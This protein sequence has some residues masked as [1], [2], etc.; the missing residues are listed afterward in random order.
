MES[1]VNFKNFWK[2]KRVL[3]TGHTGFK[4]GWLSLCL[5][6][7]GAEIVGLSLEPPTNPNFFTLT[8]LAEGIDH[9][10]C[11]IRN[12]DSLKSI[13]RKYK[14]EFIFHLAAQPL[15]RYSYINPVETYETNF[16]GT[17]NVLEAIRDVNSVR[18]A[19]LVTTDKC[20][21]NFEKE[22]GYKEDEPMGGHDP[23]SSSKG[24]AELLISSY[25]DSFF[26]SERYEEH[27]TG[28]ASARAGN[29]IGGGDWA[30]DRLIPDSISSIVNGKNINLRNPYAT[31]PWQHVLE[32][33]FGYLFLAE[34]LFERGGEFSE[35]WNFGPN[36]NDAKTVSWMV[37]SLIQTWGSDIEWKQDKEPSPHEAHYLKLDCSK[38]EERLKWQPILSPSEAIELVVSWHKSFISNE[39][40]REVSIKQIKDFV[41]KF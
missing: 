18:S 26:H 14:P 8:N 40:M 10:H 25:R 30:E 34:N 5:Q 24:A 23:Y 15:V 31:R 13:F 21:K 16:M 20:Y 9:L 27:K 1:L 36:V 11:D 4:G 38:A 33:V 12:G 17:L 29:V 28:I 19:I 32:P 41:E 7:F 35:G 2:G 6:E 3:V 39:S 22:A 37:D